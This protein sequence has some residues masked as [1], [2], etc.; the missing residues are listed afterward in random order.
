MFVI[1]I[2]VTGPYEKTTSVLF[3]TSVDTVKE[4]EGG[5][6]GVQEA[7]PAPV[8]QVSAATVPQPEKDDVS[9][10]V[11][12]NKSDDGGAHVQEASQEV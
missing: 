6:A 3:I 8:P 11:N 9:T 2:T 4:S 1:V 10:N 5:D 7:P 12:I